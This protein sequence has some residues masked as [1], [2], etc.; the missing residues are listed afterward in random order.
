MSPDYQSEGTGI[1][2]LSPLRFRQ[3]PSYSPNCLVSQSATLKEWSVQGCTRAK[4]KRTRQI[5]RLIRSILRASKLFHIKIDWNCNFVGL[6]HHPFRLQ[7]V[8]KLLDKHFQLLNPLFLAKDHWWGFITRNAHMVHIVI[9]LIRSLF[10]I[11]K[12]WDDLIILL[13]SRF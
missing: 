3:G 1:S 7:L 11:L 9:H 8:S 5:I 12:I 4:H 6:L 13:N 2:T 10:C